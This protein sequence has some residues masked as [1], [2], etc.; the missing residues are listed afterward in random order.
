[1]CEYASWE[2]EEKPVEEAGEYATMEVEHVE[3]TKWTARLLQY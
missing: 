3:A 2:V 1:V